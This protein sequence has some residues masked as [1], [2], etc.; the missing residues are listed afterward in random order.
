MSCT[1]LLLTFE[2][3]YFALK[4]KRKERNF[5]NEIIKYGKSK[6]L[7]NPPAETSGERIIQI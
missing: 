7:N 6:F 1:I 3:A 2:S 5:K 4:E